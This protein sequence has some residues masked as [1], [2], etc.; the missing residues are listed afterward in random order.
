[1]LFRCR[2]RGAGA[3]SLGAGAALPAPPHHQ[4]ASGFGAVRARASPRGVWLRA[5]PRRATLDGAVPPRTRASRTGRDGAGASGTGPGGAG[6]SRSEPDGAGASRSEP[7]RAGASRT[8]R[9]RAG[10]SRSRPRS[11]EI[12]AP[13]LRRRGKTNRVRTKRTKAPHEFVYR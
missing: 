4:E 11:W 13:G 9:E 10:A 7:E 6:R 8:G 3:A 1:M 12:R 2:H 5:S